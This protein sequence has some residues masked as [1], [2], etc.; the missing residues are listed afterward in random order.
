MSKIGVFFANGCEEIEGLTV[1]DV[2]RRAGQ[3]VVMISVTGEKMIMGSHKI[4]FVAD[5]LYE[6]VDYATL[7]GIVL[8]GGVPGTPNLEA[9][10]GVQ[11]VIREF[12]AEGKLVSAICAAPSVLGHAELLNG[13]KATCHPGYEK[14]LHGAVCLEDKVVTDGNFITS[15]GMGTANDFA[16]AIAAYFT[17]EDT[18]AQVRKGMVY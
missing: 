5:A 17:D 2:L 10:D 1:V 12:A 14:E 8:P 13:K 4:P 18:I 9:H 7:D 6:A 15:R 16:L 11:K 3:E